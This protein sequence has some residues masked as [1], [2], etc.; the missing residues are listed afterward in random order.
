MIADRFPARGAVAGLGVA[1]DRDALKQDRRNYHVG[2]WS[3]A[4]LSTS[5]TRITRQLLSGASHAIQGL[6]PA[7]HAARG[8]DSPV[9]AKHA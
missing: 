3:A 4:T 9:N 6:V 2:R 7:R 5:D 8:Q 1:R